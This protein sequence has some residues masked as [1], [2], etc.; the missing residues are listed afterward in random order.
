MSSGPTYACAHVQCTHVDQKRSIVKWAVLQV[1]KHTSEGSI[2]VVKPRIIVIGHMVLQN[3]QREKDFSSDFWLRDFPPFRQWVVWLIFG[4]VLCCGYNWNTDCHWSHRESYGSVSRL[5]FDYQL[6]S[7][8]AL[9]P[10]PFT[11]TGQQANTGTCLNLP[12]SKP[13]T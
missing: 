10:N 4:R 1:T 5:W 3:V 11:V 8:M 7:L 6:I 13:L 2:L 9:V 12:T